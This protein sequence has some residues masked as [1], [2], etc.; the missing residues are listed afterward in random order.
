MDHGIQV[1]VHLAL[2]RKGRREGGRRE[3]F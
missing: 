2:K 1:G 3:I